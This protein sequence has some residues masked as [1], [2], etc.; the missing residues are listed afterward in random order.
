[1][2]VAGPGD[3]E[4]PIVPLEV[5]G[6]VVL[7]A[8]L[9][10]ALAIAGILARA[11]LVGGDVQVQ[12]VRDRWPQVD[13]VG[14]VDVAQIVAGQGRVEPPT[15]GLLRVQAGVARGVA[16]VGGE[17]V[18]HGPR[19]GVRGGRGRGGRRSVV[20]VEG[21]EVLVHPLLRAGLGPL[22]LVA[23]EHGGGDGVHGLKHRRPRVAVV[24]VGA[25]ERRGLAGVAQGHGQRDAV[26]L[27][28]GPLVPLFDQEPAG[29]HA[30]AER[31]RVRTQALAP[32][33]RETG[34]GV[35]QGVDEVDEVAALQPA[36]VTGGGLGDAA[37]QPADAL[38]VAAGRLVGGQRGE[39]R[40]EDTEL[41]RERGQ[42]G[43]AHGGGA[44]SGVEHPPGAVESRAWVVGGR[45]ARRAHDS[46][47]RASA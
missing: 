20:T 22:A 6:V 38:V 7:A 44:P 26:Q 8:L 4:R 15:S 16:D 37:T 42:L 25:G 1:V 17:V 30:V 39:L 27:A 43:S 46:P 47:A 2:D 3:A 35:E 40:G 31:A 9:P 11:D 24:Q 18:Q 34:R 5:E 33:L 32:A 10:V 36:V 28:A 12:R 23:G 29:L 14:D 45:S 41:T 21:R 13:V 19:A